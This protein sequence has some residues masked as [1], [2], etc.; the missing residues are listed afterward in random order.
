MAE[1]SGTKNRSGRLVTWQSG[2]EVVDRPLQVSSTEIFVYHINI[3]KEESHKKG[4]S[5]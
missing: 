3:I 4:Y 1:W 2:V 5:Q